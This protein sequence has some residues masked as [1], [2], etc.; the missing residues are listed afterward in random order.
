MLDSLFKVRF[1]WVNYLILVI[2]TVLLF[3]HLS[4]LSYIA[5]FIAFHQ[6]LLL[7][8]SL[9]V[10]IPIRYLFGALMCLQFL[11]GPVL[12][13]NID[14]V[15]VQMVIPEEAYF[16]YV[17]PAV[18]CFIIGLHFYAGKLE[19]EVLH[20]ENLTRY[21]ENNKNLP[22]I[23]VGIGFLSSYMANLF[24]SDLAFL[25]Y[26][27]AG[28]KFI[29]AFMIVISSQKLK[30]FLLFIVYA[31]VIISSLN[32][33]MFHDLVIWVIFLGIIY[34]IKHKPSIP[35]RMGFIVVFIILILL[36]QTLKQYYRTAT[37]EK[38]EEAGLTT[39]SNVYEQN[40][41]KGQF[42]Q[43]ESLRSS[44]IRINQGHIV[45]HIMKTV[46]AVVPFSEGEE[47]KEILTSA[48]LPR[49]I[50]PN[51]LNAGDR[52]LF[53]KYTGLHLNYT[54][55]M[56]LSSIGD[57]YIN[58]GVYGGWFFMFLLGLLYNLTLKKFYQYSKHYPI[59]LIFMPLIFYFPI[60]PDCELQTILGHFVK[61]CFLIFVIFFSWRRQF[62]TT[63][64]SSPM[65]LETVTD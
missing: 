38:G 6:F 47:L 28:L 32:V 23:L 44:I 34:A 1:N 62:Y 39:L 42:L 20:E 5:L 14:I 4:I 45:T 12:A 61:S 37:W 48:I 24:S 35:V 30:L 16:T 65:K 31:S 26:L 18:V 40:Q 8:Y 27:I 60:R 2:L 41:A 25:F 57:A 7:F 15:K 36:L 55:S 10:V 43:T 19:G 59:I 17:I 53:A 51:K 64:S 54:T 11:F 21:L 58:F 33:G 29:G 50:A 3:P 49:I 9:G 63:S 22:L 13:Y 56:G 52:K 46:P